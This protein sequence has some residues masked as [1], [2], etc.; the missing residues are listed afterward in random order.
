MNAKGAG[1]FVLEDRS[2]Y[3]STMPDSTK[4]TTVDGHQYGERQ[5]AYVGRDLLN[6]SIGRF[7]DSVNFDNQPKALL[8]RQEQMLKAQ[9]LQ[10]ASLDGGSRL[11]SSY[12]P[13]PSGA[14]LLQCLYPLPLLGFILS[15]NISCFL[16]TSFGIYV[17]LIICFRLGSSDDFGSIIMVVFSFSFS[18]SDGFSGSVFCSSF[19]FGIG[20]E[21]VYETISSSSSAALVMNE[22]I[23]SWFLEMPPACFI[24]FPGVDRD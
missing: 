5:S 13:S 4:H 18:S 19:I 22:E 23:A 8:L 21:F 16:G 15:S 24:D 2:G 7:G 14:S 11:D 17:F 6:V 9:L 20:F 1:S 10:S 12:F 3:G